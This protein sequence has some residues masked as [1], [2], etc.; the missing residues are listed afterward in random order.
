MATNGSVAP[1][2]Q[3]VRGQIWPEYKP[4]PLPPIRR[5]TDLPSALAA[6]NQL[7][8]N[9]DKLADSSWK[10]AKRNTQRVRIH[11]A[12]NYNQWVEV[13]RITRIVFENPVTGSSFEWTYKPT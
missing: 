13:E 2:C 6:I 10:E 9:F 4:T 3:I 12:E 8:D 11:N 5:P 7:A 1:V